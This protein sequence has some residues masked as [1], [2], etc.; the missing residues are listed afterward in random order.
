MGFSNNGESVAEW[1]NHGCDSDATTNLCDWLKFRCTQI[2]QPCKG[3]A[4][5]HNAPQWLGSRSAGLA[6]WNQP[7][8]KT[9]NVEANVERLVKVWLKLKHT[10]VPIS[11]CSQIFGGIDGCA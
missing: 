9:S 2:N 10:R 8:L 1:I 7:Q 4:G 11:R 6:V 5:V 3:G